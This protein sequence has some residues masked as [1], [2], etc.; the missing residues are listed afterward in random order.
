MAEVVE[1][2]QYWSVGVCLCV[3]VSVSVC[4]YVFVF[5]F[6][7]FCFL[8]FLSSSL[9]SSS[10]IC[11]FYNNAILVLF[12]GTKVFRREKNF[13]VGRRKVKIHIPY[14][15]IICNFFFFSYLGFFLFL[16]YS[17]SSTTLLVLIH[18]R[19]ESV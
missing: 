18:N 3:C 12:A 11:S 7:S 6:H 13:Y 19:D 16:F 8:F 5:V 14:W 15:A 4:L 1:V 17:P 9:Q 10:A 2:Y